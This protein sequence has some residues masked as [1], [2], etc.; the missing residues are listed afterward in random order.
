MGRPRQAMVNECCEEA[1][2]AREYADAHLRAT[3][4]VSYTSFNDDG[5]GLKRDVLFCFD[6]RVPVDFAPVPTDGEMASFEKL[7][8]GALIESLA[9]PI[10]EEDDSDNAWKPNVGVVLIDFLL[11]KG[12]LDANDP[13][14]LAL[15][16][17]LRGATC[18]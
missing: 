5:W 4:A 9:A 10:L 13:S 14:F 8:I 15:V 12:M 7:P 18:A 3:S 16:S 11:R 17:A 2:I 1:G 6:L